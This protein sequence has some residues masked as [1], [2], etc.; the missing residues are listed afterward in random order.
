HVSGRALRRRA[1]DLPTRAAR[2]RGSRG[3]TAPLTRLAPEA[4][5]EKR[6]ARDVADPPSRLGTVLLLQHDLEVE[7]DR[8][9][10]AESEA[11]GLERGV[12]TDTEV[13]A[14]DLRRRCRA[15]LGLAIAIRHDAAELA[16][17]RY[18]LGDATQGEVSVD[19]EDVTV[20]RDRGR[21]EGQLRVLFREE[22]VAR[23]EVVV[24]GLL[25]GVDGCHV[26][27][28]LDGAVFRV[29]AGHDG[30]VDLLEPAAHLA[31]LH[32]LDGEGHL[33]VGGVELPG[34]GF[35]VGMSVN[36]VC[37]VHVNAWRSALFPDAADSRTSSLHSPVGS[38][39]D[40]EW[41]RAAP[42]R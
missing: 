22:E 15:R 3:G 42:S 38:R 13:V 40:R 32:V 18:R 28:G 14:V 23:A 37:H 36:E 16:L 11:T 17:E 29:F 25:A 39:V 27:D 41:L 30:R 24:A 20:R 6:R 2:A 1:L 8:H 12:P 19:G 7:V 33:G 4:D 35:V 31:D 21:T 10:V 9:V 34:A 5:T 26:D